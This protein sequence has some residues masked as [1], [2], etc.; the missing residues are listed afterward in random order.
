MFSGLRSIVNFVEIGSHLYGRFLGR[1]GI[2]HLKPENI[3]FRSKAEDADLMLA[4]F[5]AS[6]R[7]QMVLTLALEGPGGG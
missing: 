5:G 3:L 7:Y 1:V 6:P 2:S 4:D